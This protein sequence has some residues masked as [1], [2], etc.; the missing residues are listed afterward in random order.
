MNDRKFLTNPIKEHSKTLKYMY[1]LIEENASRNYLCTFH[2]V[3][4]DQKLLKEEALHRQMIENQLV[5]IFHH[6]LYPF[7]KT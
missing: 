1:Q 6:D 7:I 4:T 2:Q 3:S 5:T